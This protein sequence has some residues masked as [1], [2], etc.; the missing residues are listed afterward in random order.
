MESIAIIDAD[1][2]IYII[3]FGNKGTDLEYQ[4]NELDSFISKIID[5]AGCS[6]Y[7]GFLTGKGNFRY[8][9]ATI[10]PYK[11]NRDNTH[12]PEFYDQL[13][14]YLADVH[15]M[16]VVEGMEADDACGIYHYQT[17][18]PTV[19][20]TLDKD[21]DMLEGDHYNYKRDEKYYVSRVDAIRNFYLQ[22]LTG[23]SGDHIP[24]LFRV[25]GKKASK[26]MKQVILDNSKEECMDSWVWSCYYN[27]MFEGCEEVDLIAMDELHRKYQE[28]KT[29]LWIRREDETT[30]AKEEDKKA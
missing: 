4:C 27:A 29:L 13:R 14:S 8:D 3:G 24:G 1:G 11:G 10:Q 26:A 7:V 25:T 17:Q 9:V 5:R 23:D 20:C 18:Q 15:G 6:S 28:I 16:T 21:L 19:I 22:V 30:S 12:R 2:L